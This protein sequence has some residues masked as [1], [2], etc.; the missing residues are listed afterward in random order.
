MNRRKMFLPLH[1]YDRVWHGVHREKLDEI[2]PEITE[3]FPDII[4]KAV[5]FPRDNF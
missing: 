4:F 5:F 3:N 1:G 2:T